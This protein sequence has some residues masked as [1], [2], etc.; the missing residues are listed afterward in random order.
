MLAAEALLRALKSNGVDYLFANAGSDFAPVIE[1]MASVRDDGAIPE[2]ITVAHESVAVAMAHGYFLATGRAQAAM[3]H[4]NV[5]L[6][7]AAMGLINAHSDDVPV[8]ML[9]GRTPLT[10]H[11]RP[12]ARVSPI[13]YGQEQ[14]DQTSLVRDVVKWTYELRYGEQAADLVS[15]A[16][17]VAMSEPRG[18]VYLSLPREP[19]CEEVPPPR[20]PIQTAATPPAPDTAAIGEA[21]RL[22][23]DA[24]RPLIV[25]SRGDTEGRVAQALQT[26]ADRY[27]AP[28]AEVFVTRN[29]MPSRHPSMIG[30]ALGKALPTADVVLVVDTPVAWIESAVQP[31]PDATVIHI[32]QD[33]L[34][35]RM[36]VRS[37]KTDLAIAGDTASALEAITKSVSPRERNDE[38]IALNRAFREAVEAAWAEGSTGTPTKA[39]VAKCVSDILG[40]TGIVLTERGAP[41]PFFDLPNG[42]QFFGNTQAGGLGW[43]MPAALG[44]QLADRDRLVACIVGDGAY[45]FANPVAC[46]HMAEAHD[47][48]ILTVIVNND[49]WDAV[50]TSTT[51]V[52]PKGAASRANAVPMV[53]IPKG[54]DYAMIAG[55]SRAASFKVTDAEAL[56]ATLAE[57]MDIIRSERR[58]VLVDV[59]VRPD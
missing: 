6:A 46:H 32:G 44:V 33:P 18:A 25:C 19:L 26:L 23:D 54:P 17:A 45:M 57:A 11:D 5:G 21:V 52:F 20:P 43:A 38:T 12:G 2:T 50:R 48:P 8:I 42:N 10:E 27:G 15:R 31:H 37:Y 40:D 13:Q 36:P 3:V 39:Y 1:A 7:N 51:A 30:R 56:P 28:V 47:L 4:V 24:E 41:A 53:A 9:S 55:A 16:T 49:A 22:L 59:T 29:V 35:R 58:Q 34:F 14:F